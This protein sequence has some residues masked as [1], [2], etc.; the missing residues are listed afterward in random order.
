MHYMNFEQFPQQQKKEKKPS[1]ISNFIK[2]A[3]LVGTIP[4]IM[5]KAEAQNP[6][7]KKAEDKLFLPQETWVFEEGTDSVMATNKSKTYS[8]LIENYMKME[9]GKY[10]LYEYTNEDGEIIQLPDEIQKSIN[11]KEEEIKKYSDFKWVEKQFEYQKTEQ[12]EQEEYAKKVKKYEQN[13]KDQEDGIALQKNSPD[14]SAGDL[15]KD[16]IYL[17]GLRN[18]LKSFQKNYKTMIEKYSIEELKE[19]AKGYLM[20]A[21]R[22]LEML[23]EKL[24]SINKY[25][26]DHKDQK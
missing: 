13:I 19:L 10:R 3:G 17:E 9:D 14:Y 25:I 16:S 22:E 7:N 24:I 4:F 11:E 1:K 5:A 20:L 15:A 21:Q 26:E 23:R 12:Y 8:G 2:R 18:Y 6:D